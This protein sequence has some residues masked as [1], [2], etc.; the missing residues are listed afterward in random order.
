[1]PFHA[2]YS[3]GIGSHCQEIA[4]VMPDFND[5]IEEGA[6]KGGDFGMCSIARWWFLKHLGGGIF[7]FH[8]P[9]T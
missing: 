9:K 6:K 7:T 2:T 4:S 1:M 5:A 3:A 8:P